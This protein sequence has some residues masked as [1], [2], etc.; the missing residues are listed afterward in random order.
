MPKISIGTFRARLAG[1]AEAGP[2][3]EAYR[4]L[5]RCPDVGRRARASDWTI[6]AGQPDR[7]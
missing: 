1:R 6:W 7:A 5:A 2:L 4:A 3:L